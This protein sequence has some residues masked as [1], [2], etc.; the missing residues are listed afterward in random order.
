M[1]KDKSLGLVL[2]Q[3]LTLLTAQYQEIQDVK[4]RQA[5]FCDVLGVVSVDLAILSSVLKLHLV[6]PHS[7]CVDMGLWNSDQ[8]FVDYKPVI[9]WGGFYM[10]PS[11]SE[12]H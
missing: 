11:C 2:V 12:G 10:A 5:H 6:L 7:T 4:G 9:E 8:N 3:G 1:V